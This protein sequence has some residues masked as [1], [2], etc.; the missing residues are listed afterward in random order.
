MIIQKLL[1]ATIGLAV[2][3][4]AST[5]VWA[6]DRDR[7][8]ESPDWDH[9]DHGGNGNHHGHGRDDDHHGNDN[10]EHDWGDNHHGND[11][12]DEH[13]NN[14][15]GNDNNDEH[16]NNHHGNDNNHH[17]NDNNDEHDWGGNH[18]GH[19]NNNHGNDN[20]DH[21][22]NDHDNNNHHGDHDN[23]HHHSKGV[24]L[25]SI[26]FRDKGERLVALGELKGVKNSNKSV[27]ILIKARGDALA[28]CVH[29]DG[30]IL[31][32]KNPVEADEVTVVGWEE[33]DFHDFDKGVVD[34]DVATDKLDL[35][36][37]GAP[38]CPNW[39]WT[40][41][42]FDIAFTEVELIVMRDGKRVLELECFFDEPTEDGQVPRKQVDC[43][44]R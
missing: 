7:D 18:H 30:D 40:E 43:N 9:N 3:L 8:P 12:N 10:D 13:D 15:H 21:D 17:G 23:N 44:E 2:P 32:D 5:A 37:D 4:T 26:E 1:I 36:I 6:D 28:V 25:R 16:D 34:F 22:N 38:D 41:Q 39:K 42:I 29:P 24:E 27:E 14:H 11:N 35:E 31:P 20:N 19:D 33:L